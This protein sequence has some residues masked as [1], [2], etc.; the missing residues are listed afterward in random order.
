MET[1]RRRRMAGAQAQGAETG[2]NRLLH[3]RKLLNHRSRQITTPNADTLY[4]DAWI[5][6]RQG[7]ARI[8]LPR[9]GDR[10]VSLAL[11]DMW[12]NNFAVLGSRATGTDGGRFTL[13]G[14]DASA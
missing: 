9:H 10:Y 6:L 12:T 1:L 7:P 5:D 4:T 2:M 3:A 11:M 14:P 8:A 13:V